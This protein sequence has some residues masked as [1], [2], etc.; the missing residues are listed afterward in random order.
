MAGLLIF[1]IIVLILCL[2]PFVS[3]RG[4][5]YFGINKLT[6]VA[7]V[8]EVL[9]VGSICVFFL[10]T[11]IV[12][13]IV[14]NKFAAEQDAH[15]KVKNLALQEIQISNV[16][17]TPARDST[18]KILYMKL[19]FD[20][21]VT[22]EGNYSHSLSVGFP[23]VGD[24]K[25]NDVFEENSPGSVIHFAAGETKTFTYQYRPTAWRL[26]QNKPLDDILDKDILFTFGLDG[27]DD[28]KRYIQI[29]NFQ[30]K[31][32]NDIWNYYLSDFNTNFTLPLNQSISSSTNR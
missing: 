29:D 19:T 13:S 30:F 8:L 2:I 9:F 7:L 27:N 16:V 25:P 32:L 4:R 28:Y 5:E 17:D 10:Y 22:K 24:Q 1:F 18:N 20:I 21:T 23:Y 26:E 15:T 3:R 11:T 31:Y 12:S 6:A 14:E